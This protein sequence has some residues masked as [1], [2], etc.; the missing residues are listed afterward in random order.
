MNFGNEY[1]RKAVPKNDKDVV[2]DTVEV[3]ERFDFEEEEDFS[4][5]C[6]DSKD[7]IEKT[8]IKCEKATSSFSCN[9]NGNGLFE[10]F[11]LQS[12]ERPPGTV[13]GKHNV[14]VKTGD[15]AVLA[16]SLYLFI[17]SSLP[18]SCSNRSSRS[19]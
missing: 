3:G 15:E 17:E 19:P 10:Q 5:G 7:S 2:D 1:A 11:L 14:E 13:P 18:F 12:V 9:G 16:H 4:A 6:Y 8:V